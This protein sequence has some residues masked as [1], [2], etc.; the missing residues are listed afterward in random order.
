MPRARG[1]ALRA[2]ARRARAQARPQARRSARAAPASPASSS[3]C[4]SAASRR[5]CSRSVSAASS[6][7]RRS[8]LCARACSA[9]S[10]CCDE[11]A[12][13]LAASRP[14]GASAGEVGLERRKVERLGGARRPPTGPADERAERVDLVEALLLA[15]RVELLALLAHDLRDRRAADDGHDRLVV[16]LRPVL[17]RVSPGRPVYITRG[18]DIE[19]DDEARASCAFHGQANDPGQGFVPARLQ[20]RWLR[21][22]TPRPPTRAGR[23]SWARP[24]ATWR[25][26]P[27]TRRRS[28]GRPAPARERGRVLAREIAKLRQFNREV[29]CA[30]AGPSR[31]RRPP[32]SRPR[33]RRRWS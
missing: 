23:C 22:P 26:R 2:R 16:E 15:L 33:A 4:R 3:F 5:A 17:H 29:A 12:S 8:A 19:S 30:R 7:F 11:A 28:A 31:C 1:R 21:R 25:A 32:P 18:S 14:L 6:S 27:S 13:P 20:A 24:A 9:R 10:R